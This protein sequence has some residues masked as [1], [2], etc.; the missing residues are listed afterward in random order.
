MMWCP[1]VF[2]AAAG[3]PEIKAFTTARRLELVVV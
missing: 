3:A 1:V 2:V